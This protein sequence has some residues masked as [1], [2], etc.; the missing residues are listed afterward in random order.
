MPRRANGGRQVRGSLPEFGAAASVA[1]GM[2]AGNKEAISVPPSYLTSACRIALAGTSVLQLL[3]QRTLLEL[4]LTTFVAML[5]AVGCARH[6]CCLLRLLPR[7]CPQ[8][9]FSSP[10]LRADSACL[11]GIK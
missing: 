4:L 2:P 7:K 9:C 1:P 10:P 3:P 11:S 8:E 5:L 6:A